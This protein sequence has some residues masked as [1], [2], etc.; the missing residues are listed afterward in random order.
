MSGSTVICPGGSAAI[1]AALGGTSPWTVTWSDGVVQS[2]IVSSPASRSVSPSVTT[3]YSVTNVADAYCSNS[4]S[5]SAT[6]TV[7]SLPAISSQPSP[8][9]ACD[10]SIAT[11]TVVASGTGITYR[12][13]KDGI[14]LVNGGHVSGA[15]S[16]TLTISSAAAADAG[17][18][19]VVVSGTCPPAQTSNAAS[20]IVNPRPNAAISAADR[21]CDG[22]AGNVGYTTAVDWR[23]RSRAFEELAL[24]RSWSATLAIDGEPQRIAGI[25]NFH[26][27]VVDLF[28][29]D[30]VYLP[31]LEHRILQHARSIE[32]AVQ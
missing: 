23:S 9:A 6:V 30:A 22:S 4:G 18:Y 20:L 16:A 24:I 13:R 28:R 19:D 1:Q 32:V 11:F 25:A 17:S 26:R 2:G 8:K 15:T 31:H 21:Q 10:G 5:G 7:N 3:V 27:F 14:N 12:W 29:L